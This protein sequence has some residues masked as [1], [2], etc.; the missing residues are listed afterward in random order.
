M[1]R[2]RCLKPVVFGKQEGRKEG[3][4]EGEEDYATRIVLF[5]GR[6][7]EIPPLMAFASALHCTAAA[8]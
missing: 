7:N 1:Y 5:A 3:R 2:R 6:D 4:K 8:G